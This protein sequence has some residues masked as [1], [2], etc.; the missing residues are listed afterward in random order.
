MAPGAWCPAGRIQRNR[1]ACAQD[2]SFAKDLDT[3]EFQFE[4]PVSSRTSWIMEH[5]NRIFIPSG[6]MNSTVGKLWKHWPMHAEKN[7]TAL[8]RIDGTV[9]RIAHAAHQGS[10]TAD[11]RDGRTGK[12]M[13]VVCPSTT[14][15]GRYAQRGR[16]NN[17]WVFELI[18]R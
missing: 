17:L 9:Y 11:D 4:D 5:D 10:R 7:G 13:G 2:W 16:S 3:V 1:P 18:R 8:L 14:L 12:Y 6:Y 15:D